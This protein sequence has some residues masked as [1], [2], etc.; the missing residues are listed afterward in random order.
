M[1]PSRAARKVGCD[2]GPQRPYK[3]MMLDKNGGHNFRVAR[4]MAASHN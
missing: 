4:I 2:K 1:F 3:L